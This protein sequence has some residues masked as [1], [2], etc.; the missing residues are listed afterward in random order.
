ME[1]LE[2]H[3]TSL[4]QH[5]AYLESTILQL[6][7]GIDINALA[8]TSRGAHVELTENHS[9]SALLFVPPYHRILVFGY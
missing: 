2:Q 1:S 6:Q 5:V 4:E 7:P 8:S 9:S 3:N